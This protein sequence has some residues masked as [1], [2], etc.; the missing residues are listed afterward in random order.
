MCRMIAAPLGISGHALVTPFLRM[1]RGFNGVNEVNPALGTYT[2]GHGWGAI[3]GG[4]EREDHPIRSAAACWNDEG[5]QALADET[6]LLLHA[7]MA[8][9]GSVTIENVHPF[10][11]IL[12]GRVWSYCHN[13]TVRQTLEQPTSLFG[14]DHTDSE[15]V[16]HQLLARLDTYDIVDAIRD[17]YGDICDY[18]ALNSFL[19]GPDALWVV[20]RH[21][22]TPDYFALHLAISSQGP[23]I[24]SEPLEEFGA[25]QAMENGQILRID[26]RDGSIDTFAL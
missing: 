16:F 11:A 20:C 25:F 21:A 26:R 7:R 9:R 10:Q 1:A 24:S 12:D 14:S 6:V 13:G 2:H 5:I 17:I 18:T 22:T 15:I 19:L 3:I 8:S 23:I 4:V